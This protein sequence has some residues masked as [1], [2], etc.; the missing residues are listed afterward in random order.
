MMNQPV[1]LIGLFLI[2][3]H[4]GYLVQLRLSRRDS[5]QDW[6]W[7]VFLLFIL[8]VSSYH[9]ATGD[10]SMLSTIM[11]NAFSVMMVVVSATLGGW[12]FH[13][14]RQGER[15]IDLI[16]QYFTPKLYEI[17]VLAIL[18]IVFI[19]A[20][21][22]HPLW[23]FIIGG[24]MLRH[25]SDPWAT[26]F[27]IA[28]TMLGSAAD[29]LFKVI[30]I[31]GVLLLALLTHEQDTP[32]T[33]QVQKLTITKHVLLS[34]MYVLIIAIFSVIGHLIYGVIIAGGVIFVAYI[35]DRRIWIELKRAYIAGM[36]AMMFVMACSLLGLDALHPNKYWVAIAMITPLLSVQ[37]ITFCAVSPSYY[38]MWREWIQQSWRP[39]LFLILLTIFF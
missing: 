8:I 23:A 2:I 26:I 30:G 24:M 18:T 19:A 4:T 32:S 39:L 10:L 31:G 20:W 34:L 29:I 13:E 35:T 17:L 9:L 25:S 21:L 3:A 27:L 11:P 5:S 12:L 38:L 33:K 1:V 7:Y 6:I 14:G 15:V 16:S 22:I 37:G 28:A 36:T